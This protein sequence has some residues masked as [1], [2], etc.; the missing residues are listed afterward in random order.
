MNHMVAAE[1]DLSRK[2]LNKLGSDNSR[3][4]QRVETNES[5][6]VVLK[7]PSNDA[8]AMSPTP[9]MHS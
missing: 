3:N 9:S 2:S 8:N 4:N 6:Y 1:N 5:N 7:H